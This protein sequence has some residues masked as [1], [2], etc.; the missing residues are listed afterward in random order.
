MACPVVFAQQWEVGEIDQGGVGRGRPSR[1]LGRPRPEGRGRGAA[2]GGRR[3]PGPRPQWGG[4]WSGSEIGRGWVCWWMLGARPYMERSGRGRQIKSHQSF[5]RRLGP[6]GRQR[7][8]KEDRAVGR[9]VGRVGGSTYLVEQRQEDTLASPHKIALARGRAHVAVQLGLRDRRQRHGLGV[10][11]LHRRLRPGDSQ[12]QPLAPQRSVPAARTG[13]T[14]VGTGQQEKSDGRRGTRHGGRNQAAR[15]PKKQIQSQRFRQ[16][17]TSAC[18]HR[19][20]R[21][22]GKEPAGAGGKLLAW[23]AERRGAGWGDQ[24]EKVVNQRGTHQAQRAARR[25]ATS[26][27][28]TLSG[29]VNCCESFLRWPRTAD[30]LCARGRA[31]AS[32]MTSTA[33]VR[34]GWWEE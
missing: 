34:G 3:E 4:P 21:A 9:G 26:A 17:G 31:D 18:G 30:T 16:L 12:P 15:K 29:V 24:G 20:R 27:G 5:C 23:W 1:R 25:A 22:A 6:Q 13:R 33:W 2:C 10:R 7:K 28:V 8:R 11:A 32:Q 19:G 14:R